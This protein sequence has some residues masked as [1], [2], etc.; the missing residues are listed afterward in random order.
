[1]SCN[2]VLTNYER[3]LKTMKIVCRSDLLVI[4][5]DFL[6]VSVLRWSSDWAGDR[7]DNTLH[8]QEVCSSCSRGSLCGIPQEKSQS[9]QCLHAAY[10]GLSL[11]SQSLISFEYNIYSLGYYSCLKF[12][13]FIWPEVA[14]IT[15]LPSNNCLF[16]ICKKINQW[17]SENKNLKLKLHFVFPGTLVWRASACQSLS[18]KHWQE[19]WR[20]PCCRGLYRHRFG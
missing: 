6:Q 15:A 12:L 7:D 14:L 18:G 8:G 13:H 9:R 2:N 5:I 4:T 1:M 20:C 16:L 17:E 3:F 10:T 11:Q 19:H